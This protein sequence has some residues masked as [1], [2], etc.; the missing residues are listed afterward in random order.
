MKK[1]LLLFIAPVFVLGCKDDKTQG[2]GIGKKESTGPD[3]TQYAYKAGYSSDV[4]LGDR[5]HSKLVLDFI[6]A[7]EENRMKDMR[8]LLADSVEATFAD[9]SK[10]SGTADSLISMGQTYRDMYSTVKITVDVWMPVHL[11]DKN[12]DYVLVWERDYNT[13]KQGKVDSL[14]SHAYYQI[15]NNRIAG[16]SEFNSKL[17]PPAEGPIK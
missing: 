11:N 15:K 5:N 13:D 14:G 6:K 16:W 9:G 3:S 4:S 10:F 2:V 17:A 8:S 1:Y 7:W 12:E